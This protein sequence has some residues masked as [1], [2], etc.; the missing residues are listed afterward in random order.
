VSRARALL[1]A[2]LFLLGLRRAVADRGRIVPRPRPSR[3]AETVVLALLGLAAACSVGFIAVYALDRIPRQTQ[4]LGLTLG[5]A[6]AFLAAA[7]VVVARRVLPDEEV[8]H[9]YPPAEHEPEQDEVVRIVEESKDAFTRRRLLGLAAGGAGATLGAALLTPVFSLGPFLDTDTLYSSPWSR[10]RRLVDEHG[11][12]IRARDIEPD[13]FYNAYPEGADPEQVASPLVTA[14]SP[15]RRSAPTPAARS[16]STERRSTGRPPRSR[17]SS[18]RV[19][20]RRS[21]R[22][23]AAPS[24]SAPPA[25][26]CRSCRSRSTSRG[27]CAPRAASPTRS[28]RRG[29]GCG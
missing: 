22:P 2:L 24:S 19:T 27:T 20:T 26:R 10:G 12:P 11:R 9:G 28:G 21:T 3:R 14:S 29:G 18:A 6:L 8:E 1:A 16:P 13:E 7:C 15:T 17:R 23:P 5:L 4:F 25:A